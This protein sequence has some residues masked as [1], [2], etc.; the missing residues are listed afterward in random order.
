MRIAK[1]W[2][3]AA[4]HRLAGLAEGHKCGRTHGHNYVVDLEMSGP[5]D[6]AGMVFDYGR[7]KPF[8]DYIAGV[9]DHQD[10]N[11]TL[12]FNPTAELLAEH[13][14]HVAGTLFHGLPRGVTITAVRVRE[15][16]RT[17]AEFP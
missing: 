15:T 6:D 9:L 17:V 1:S 16:D 3:F 5:I 7:M 4:S 2:T 14:H 10:L 13:L 8:G 11:E 12:S